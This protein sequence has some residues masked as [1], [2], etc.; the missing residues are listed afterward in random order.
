MKVILIEDVPQLGRRGE[1]QE[2]AAGYAR[3][4]LVPKKLAVHASPENL[5]DLDRIRGRQERL[6][7]RARREAETLAS[8]ISAIALTFARQAGEEGKLFG[9][10]TPSDIIKALAA[11]GIR[12]EKRQIHL[13]EPLKALG[14]HAVPM[15]LHPEVSTE[16]RVQ[17]VPK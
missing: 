5:R 13:E 10:V 4:Y 9:S 6:V 3:N 2:V 11:E 14:D 12:I 16:V 1:V 7:E 8:R 15:R 17:I